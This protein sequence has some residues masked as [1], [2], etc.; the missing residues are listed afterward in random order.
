MGVL[1]AKAI[2]LS[3]L[4]YIAM[5]IWSLVG[6]IVYMFYR[7]GHGLVGQSE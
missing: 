4:I 7:K 6:G 1:E 3:L 2:L 5:L